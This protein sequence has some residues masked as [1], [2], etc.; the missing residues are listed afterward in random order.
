MSNFNNTA[1]ED[2]IDNGVLET[3]ELLLETQPNY[4]PANII[5]GAIDHK[6]WFDDDDYIYFLEALAHTEK[7][8]KPG[9]EWRAQRGI[10][11]IIN[12]FFEFIAKHG[13]AQFVSQIRHK[14]DITVQT[15]MHNGR[16]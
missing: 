3:I 1:D 5:I 10:D 6:G 9:I 2:I 15:L 8:G 16:I 11:G 12:R 7:I 4:S 13:N 14:L